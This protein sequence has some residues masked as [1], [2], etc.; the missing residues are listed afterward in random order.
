VIS[1]AAFYGPVWFGFFLKSFSEKLA[2]GK[3]W[4]WGEAGG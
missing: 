3:S 2:V 1:S 4:L